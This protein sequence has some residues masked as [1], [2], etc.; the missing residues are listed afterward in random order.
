[1]SNKIA[2]V[3]VVGHNTNNY[4]NT[5]YFVQSILINNNE[6]TVHKF[7][8]YSYNSTIQEYIKM[9]KNYDFNVTELQDIDTIIK[10]Q[11]KKPFKLC[12]NLIVD[13][14]SKKINPEYYINYLSY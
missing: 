1:M 4:G 5:T 13:L 8:G 2:T 3:Q 10:G 14:I 12:T 6:I 7:C 11:S 9:L